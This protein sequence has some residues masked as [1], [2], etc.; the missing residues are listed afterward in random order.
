MSLAAV[1]L[2]GWVGSMA[3][4]ISAPANDQCAGAVALI[5]GLD[6]FMNTTTA[7]DTGDPVIPYGNLHQGVWFTFTPATTEQVTVSTCPSD[8]DTVLQVFQGTC[9]ALQRVPY[10]FNDDSPSCGTISRFQSS[11][12]F[13]GIAGTTYYI[14][15]GGLA[16]NSGNLA[17]KATSGLVNDECAGALV[18]QYGVPFSMTTAN[19]TTGGGDPTPTCQNSFGKTVWFSFQSPIT[20]N[21]PISTCGS[22]FDTVAQVF[23]GSCGRLVP[24]ICG[25]NNGPYC[26]GP[27]ASLTLAAT[28]DGQYYVMVAGSASASGTLAIVVGTPPVLTAVRSGTNVSLSWPTH[29]WPWYVLQQ[30]TTDL[31]VSGAWNDILPTPRA[32]VLVPATAPFQFF[33]LTTP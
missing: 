10:G 30:N 2:A 14:L 4:A 29:Y 8:F 28:I 24:V 6:Y 32:S 9:G 1:A 18:L 21:V 11:V 12:A 17:I 16:G 3:A 19:A 25:D 13:S 31:G 27:Q 5:N 23:T 22:S 33:R 20:G 26:A 7:T 15:V